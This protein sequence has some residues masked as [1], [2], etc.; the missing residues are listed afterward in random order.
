MVFVFFLS[1]YHKL[2]E[3][4]SSASIS[5][6]SCGTVLS[7]HRLNLFRGPDSGLPESSS[8]DRHSVVTFTTRLS[9]HC[10]PSQVMVHTPEVYPDV[11]IGYKVHATRDHI[12]RVAVSV[13][14]VMADESL[15]RHAKRDLLQCYVY[16]NDGGWKNEAPYFKSHDEDTCY[17]KCRLRTIHEM[18]NCTQYFFDL[19]KGRSQ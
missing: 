12:S 4:K 11:S 15:G 19:Y 13:D 2:N 6:R 16:D 9:G 8:A 1:Y 5:I 17:T 14:Q 7:K 18:C 10:F 3:T